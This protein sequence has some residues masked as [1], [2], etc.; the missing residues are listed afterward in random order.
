M[1]ATS[2]LKPEDCTTLNGVLQHCFNT[3][4]L[5]EKCKNCGLPVEEMEAINNSHIE[6]AKNL[7]AQF[8]P[9]NP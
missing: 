7:K 2:P 9:N 3:A 4:D 1:A 8:F 5:I 6:M